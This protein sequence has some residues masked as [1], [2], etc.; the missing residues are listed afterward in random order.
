MKNNIKLREWEPS[1]QQY[2]IRRTLRISNEK[3]ITDKVTKVTLEI[4]IKM[5][6]FIEK[7]KW[8]I[9]CRSKN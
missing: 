2:T 7:R 3:F 8:Q 1:G 9:K 6:I 5:R 4:W